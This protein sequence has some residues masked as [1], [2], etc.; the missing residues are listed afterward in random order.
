M[1]DLC[2]FNSVRSRGKRVGR[3]IGSG[4]GKTCGRGHKGQHARSSNIGAFEGG[5]LSIVRSLPK[6]GFNS[7]RRYSARAAAVTLTRISY[8]IDSGK[9]SAGDV[10]DAASCAE[11]GLAPRGTKMIKVIGGGS[12]NVSIVSLK[13]RVHKMS[14]GAQALI[15]ESG[16]FYE[17]L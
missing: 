16:G 12:E 17:I 13:F 4:K 10:I 8:L 11:L 14:M 9:L 15:T 5:Q 7:N 1:L 6:R 3:G 2:S